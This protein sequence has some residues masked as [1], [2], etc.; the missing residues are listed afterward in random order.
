MVRLW[1]VVGDIR[2]DGAERNAPSSVYWPLRSP[3]SLTYIVRGA[4]AGSESLANESRQTV[5]SV[6]S[7]IPITEMRTMK[8]VYDRSM[9]R[10]SFT[11]TLLGISGGMALLL[12]VVGIYAVISYSV[13]QRT[14]GSGSA[15]RSVLNVAV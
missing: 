15:W 4:R 11:L 1:E 10:T 14:E 13:T 7:S 12:A 2:H 5:L 8:E 9:S 6:N 3:F